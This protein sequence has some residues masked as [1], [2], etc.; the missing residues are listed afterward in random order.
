MNSKTTNTDKHKISDGYRLKDN[1][2]HTQFAYCAEDITMEKAVEISRIKGLKS[3]CFTEHAP[4]LYLTNKEYYSFKFYHEPDMI[5]KRKKSKLNRVGHFRKAFSQLNSDIA[6][7]GLEVELDKDGRLAL[8]EEDRQNMDLFLGAIH[9]IPEEYLDNS[10]KLNSKFMEENQKLMENRINVLA[11]PFRFFIRGKLKVPKELFAPMAK[12]LKEKN[13]AAE[14]NF[15]TNSP[16]PEF[17]A[18]CLEEGVKLSLG[19]DSHRLSEVGDLTA[20]MNFMKKLGIPP[21]KIDSYLL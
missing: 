19:T 2:C 10:R 3:I 15:H 14:I 18:R 17:F 13:V 1:H 20:H 5:Q 21:E 12:M 16:D 4:H 6:K 8:I 7:I 9:Y 11:H